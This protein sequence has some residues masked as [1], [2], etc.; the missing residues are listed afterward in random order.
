MK[1]KRQKYKPEEDGKLATS[2]AMAKMRS[3]AFDP[4]TP[5][6]VINRLDNLHNDDDA[7]SKADAKRARKQ[8]KLAALVAKGKA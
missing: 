3:I 8:T 5:R 1:M 2:L 7:V 4:A 6:R